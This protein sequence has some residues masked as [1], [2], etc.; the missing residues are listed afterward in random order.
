MSK[1]RLILGSGS[2]QRERLLKEAGYKFEVIRPDDKA[3]SGICSNCGPATL[4]SDLALRKAADVAQQLAHQHSPDDPSN[5]PASL[6]IACDTVA[7]CGG[8]ILGKPRNEDH[9][10]EMLEQL[11]GT[12]HRVYS[13]LCLWPIGMDSPPRPIETEVATSELKMDTISSEE[14]ESYLETGL[15]QGKAGAFGLQDRPEW[16]HIT[17]G[18]ESNVIGL[19]MELLEKMLKPWKLG[20]PSD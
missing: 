14:I 18:S 12:M 19:P 3:E 16:L 4:V 5:L 6:I 20:S 17:S 9:A 7:E 13:G 11:S 2:P 15:W 10:C 1:V 8:T